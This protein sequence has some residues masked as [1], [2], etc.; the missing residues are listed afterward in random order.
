MSDA[1]ENAVDAASPSGVRSIPPVQR[2]FLTAGGLG[3]MR[4]ASG[5]WGSTPPPAMHR[6]ETSIV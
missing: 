1:R 6:V 3:L 4:P 2:F 5:T